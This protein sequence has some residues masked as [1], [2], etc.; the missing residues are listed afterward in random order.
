MRS[1][2]FFVH[3][4]LWAVA[5]LP[6]DCFC[7]VGTLFFYKHKTY[8]HLEAEIHLKNKHISSIWPGGEIVGN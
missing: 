7:Y 4:G 8:K 1:S 6:V 3:C 5:I 2:L